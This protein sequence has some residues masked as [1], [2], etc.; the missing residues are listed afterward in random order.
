MDKPTIGSIDKA[1][2]TRLIQAASQQ[3]AGASEEL[4]AILYA[5]LRRLAVQ[6]MRSERAN[7]T[8]QPTA[9][10]H[11]AYLR[12][13]SDPSLTWENRR[14]FFGAAAESMR[15][16][17]IESVRFKRRIKR[18]GDAAR[19]ALDVQN[20]H[21][22]DEIDYDQVLDFD[23]HI[24]ALEQVD[25][26]LARIVKLR[27]YAGQ[28]MEDISSMLDMS[29]STVERRWRFARAWLADRMAGSSDSAE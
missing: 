29:L 9:L 14:H 16:I 2:L 5:E 18:G 26:E 27:F 22:C 1:Q 11:E 3:D 19:V 23:E 24:T 25:A 17:L 13:L 10:V 21:S 15:R 4:F 20:L 7:H 8:L 28:S 6:K 12:L